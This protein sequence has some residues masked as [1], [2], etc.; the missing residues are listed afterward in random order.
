MVMHTFS[1]S[2]GPSNG[3][4]CLASA[5]ATNRPGVASLNPMVQSARLN[6]LPGGYNPAASLAPKLVKRIQTC[7]LLM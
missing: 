5:A 2:G 3:L 6:S 4:N 1:L 7:S